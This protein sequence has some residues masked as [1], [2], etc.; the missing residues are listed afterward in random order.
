M[1]QKA[2]DELTAGECHCFA[3]LAVGVVLVLKADLSV[4]QFQQSLIRN[5]DAMG[6][7][8]Q[9]PEHL[10]WPAEGAL[11]VDNPVFPHRDIDLPLQRRGLC[12]VSQPT[13]ELK[14][15]SLVRLFHKRDELA[16]INAT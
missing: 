4:F 11:G 9:I 1:H 3:S 2:A 14:L 15:A 6:I 7:P 5:S 10:L 12:Q 13:M 8:G 16:A